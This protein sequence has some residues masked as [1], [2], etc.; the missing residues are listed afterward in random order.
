VVHIG[1]NVF[2]IDRAD[3]LG[4]K[5]VGQRLRDSLSR[6]GDDAAGAQAGLR[7]GGKFGLDANH[8]HLGVTKLGLARLKIAELYGGRDATD[9]STSADRDQHGFNVGEV[10][11]DFE[12]DGSLAG[13]DLL[14]VVGRHDR[15]AVLGGQLFGAQAALFTARAD[16]DNLRSE[17]G[18]G[19]EFVPGSI[20]GHDD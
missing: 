10:F 4:A 3:A 14:V 19:F 16:G 15:V 9:Q 12:P 1:A 7:I 11:E 18:G 17:G 20:A 5:T 6:E 13:N 2:E 8:L